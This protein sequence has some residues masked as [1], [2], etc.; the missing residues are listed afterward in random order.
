MEEAKARGE[1]VYGYWDSTAGA[2]G[3]GAYVPAD[4][5]EDVACAE[6]VA[7]ARLLA[8]GLSRSPHALRH[9]YAVRFLVAREGAHAG[10]AV[11]TIHIDQKKVG[12]AIAAEAIRE[13]LQTIVDGDPTGSLSIMTSG[14]PGDELVAGRDHVT[15]TY[16]LP[17]GRELVYE[18]AEGFF[19]N[20]SHG[21]CVFTVAWLCDA[22]RKWVPPTGSGGRGSLLELYCGNGNHT[23]A[24]APLFDRVVGVEI[25]PRLVGAANRNLERNAAANAALAAAEGIG[26][27]RVEVLA[28]PSAKFCNR[29]LRTRGRSLARR[30]GGGDQPFDTILVDPPRCGLDEKTLALVGSF[31]TVLY[32]SCEPLGSLRRDMRTLGATHEVAEMAVIGACGEPL[33]GRKEEGVA[34]RCAWG[35]VDARGSSARAC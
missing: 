20:P 18:Q 13:E 16:A 6:L 26:A 10:E 30:A 1:C 4:D 25:H 23:V 12:L 8:A 19:S 29:V 32:I 24:L 11:C 5:I 27:G 28:A 15:E 35:R 33:G 7:A 9:A 34:M 2:G 31:S 3:Q 17:D 21:A 22:I 14:L